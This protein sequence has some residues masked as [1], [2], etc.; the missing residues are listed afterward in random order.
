MCASA[1]IEIDRAQPLDEI[2]RGV[3]P[4][5]PH[6]TPLDY[7]AWGAHGGTPLHDWRHA[8]IVNRTDSPRLSPGGKQSPHRHYL[9][10]MVGGVI[11]NEHHLA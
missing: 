3:P 8:F 7:V 2:C 5:A 6:V 4:W 1:V 9:T 11:C 10:C